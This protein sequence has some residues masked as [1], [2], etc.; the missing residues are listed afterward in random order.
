MLEWTG[1]KEN[2]D[3]SSLTDLAAFHI[4]RSEGDLV[5]E[6]CRGCGGK[7]HPV[8]EMT[9]EKKDDVKGKKVSVFFE[10]LQPRKVYTFVVVSVNRRG[11]PSA[12]SNPAQIFWDEARP[13]PTG[14]NGERGDKRVDLTWES[15]GGAGGYNLYRRG[16]DESFPVTPLNRTVLTSTQYTDL[17]VEN[18]KKYFYTVRSLKR[19]V[20]S[21]V[22]GKGSPEVAVIPTD[23][24]APSAP[25]GLVAIPLKQGIEL[26]WDRNRERDLLGYLV[27]RKKPEEGSFQ[28]L[29]QTP[30]QK[31]TYLDSDVTLGQDYDYAV[32]ALDKSTNR[33]E[34]QFSEEV[35]VK[36]QY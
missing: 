27:Y 12:A 29:T 5:G 7:P 3:K 8:Y 4:L 32:T 14:V 30:L 16:E 17:G 9:L 1:P 22:E 10:D 31:E 34:S 24:I 36:N 11:Y 21:D 33:N 35:R 15:V 20:K 25:V 19:I 2:T 26:N 18:D 13:P 28:K 6:E 23:L